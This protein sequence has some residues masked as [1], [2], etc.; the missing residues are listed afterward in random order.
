MQLWRQQ[1]DT[2][3]EVA[4]EYDLEWRQ[5][6]RMV[7]TLL[8]M[9]FILRLVFSHNGQGYA[10]V[11]AEFWQQCRLLGII[12]PKAQP[13]SVSAMSVARKKVHESAFK[14]LQRRILQR[15][16][17]CD[18]F[19]WRGRRLYAVN[20]S[21]INLPRP[22]RNCGYRMPDEE[23]R[24]P[25][26]LVSCLY[27]LQNKLLIDFDLAAHHD[28]RRMALEHLK[29]L[30]PTDVVAYDRGYYGYE[31]LREHHRRRVD[32]IFRMRRSGSK[33]IDQF[34][35]STV[36]EAIVKVTASAEVRQRIRARQAEAQCLPLTLRLVKYAVADQEH[37]LA[38]TLLDGQQFSTAGLSEVYHSPWGIEETSENSKQMMM[39]KQFRAHSE[40]G[41]KQELYAHFVQMTWRRQSAKRQMSMN[42]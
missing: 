3:T 18:A 17:Q 16:G 1:I 38:T 7:S 6:R 10:T 13:V 4:M 41:V 32:V 30:K 33:V 9:L 36:R 15:Q 34:M 14:Q 28:E 2:L 37:A 35:Q 24:L 25:Q 19:R 29:A 31:L 27:Q 23:A 5:R 26:G 12:L 40:R 39:I 20:S 21:T 42:A 8:V 11:L 22:L